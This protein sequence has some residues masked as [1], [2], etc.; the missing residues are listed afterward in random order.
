[1]ATA[2]KKQEERAD[3]FDASSQPEEDECKAF[4]KKEEDEDSI[5]MGDND[6]LMST[7][8]ED[9]GNNDAFLKMTNRYQ[10]ISKLSSSY[11]DPKSEVSEF[12]ASNQNNEKTKSKIGSDKLEYEPM[13]YFLHFNSL[14]NKHNK[15]LY[16]K[17]LH[18]PNY[19]QDFTRKNSSGYL[20][21]KPYHCTK[22]F[23]G[24]PPNSPIN[25][26]NL[27][28]KPMYKSLNWMEDFDME[29]ND[30]KNQDEDSE[31]C[32][33]NGER[34]CASDTEPE[35]NFSSVKYKTDKTESPSDKAL[36]IDDKN[37]NGD[38]T[39]LKADLDSKNISASNFEVDKLHQKNKNGKVI[40]CNNNSAN[41]HNFNFIC[42]SFA[43][44][45]W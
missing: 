43:Q 5:S 14:Q 33:K 42:K 22:T 44:E 35:E 6:V 15:Q 32:N 34:V 12:A 30:K 36:D 39:I 2:K 11:I 38:K 4:D 21:P 13:K 28:N 9:N 20:S 26:N 31:T 23:A 7:G 18:P 19:D 3:L 24:N 16:T 25:F 27:K 17:N 37:I 40:D 45:D 41:T 8:S 10:K 1:M 29:E